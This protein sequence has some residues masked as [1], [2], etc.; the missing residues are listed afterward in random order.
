M[1]ASQPEVGTEFNPNAFF[2]SCIYCLL[3]LCSHIRIQGRLGAIYPVMGWAYNG[4][5]TD[6]RPD[7]MESARWRKAWAVINHR[8]AITE[9]KAGNVKNVLRAFDKEEN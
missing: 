5:Q 7:L 1:R 3:S 8:E 4:R 6:K 9:S 2:D